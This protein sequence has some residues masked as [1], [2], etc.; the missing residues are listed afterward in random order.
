M[1]TYYTVYTFCVKDGSNQWVIGNLQ[2]IMKG[3]SPFGNHN[4][5][6]VLAVIIVSLLG[7]NGTFFSKV[8]ATLLHFW[9]SE[10]RDAT[11]LITLCPKSRHIS[12]FAFNFCFVYN[13]FKV[14]VASNPIW[15]DLR[16]FKNYLDSQLCIRMMNLFE[17]AGL[18]YNLYLLGC[19]SIFSLNKG[20]L[21]WKCLNF[22]SN[23]NPACWGIGRHDWHGFVIGQLSAAPETL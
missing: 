19:G 10:M 6:L 11:T 22:R 13:L 8:N 17:C 16:M 4:D 2:S 20:S 5:D 3:F 23:S 14:C 12:N 7:K 1:N 15:Y 9:C 21:H 18:L